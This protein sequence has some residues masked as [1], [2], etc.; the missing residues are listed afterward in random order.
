GEDLFFSYFCRMEAR[1]FNQLKVNGRLFTGEEIISFC[2]QQSEAN[3]RALGK[4]MEEW[5]SPDLSVTLQTSGSTGTPKQIKVLK[6]QM[7]NSAAMTA[8]YFNFQAGQ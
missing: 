2:E 7:L 4:F 1:L 3:V 6:S 8:Q 5:L